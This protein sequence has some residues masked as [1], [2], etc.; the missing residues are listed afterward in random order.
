MAGTKIT[1][2]YTPIPKSYAP[3][4]CS[5]ET[6]PCFYLYLLIKAYV[7]GAL[8]RYITTN[9]SMDLELSHAKG[10]FNLNELKKYNRIGI[11]AAGSG[12]TPMLEIIDYL[13]ERRTNKMYVKIQN[14]FLYQF[15]GVFF[16]LISFIF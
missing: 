13:L 6:D 7:D 4:S 12:L 11:L 16:L 14:D 9:L 5:N 10:S 3:I 15:F 1:R 8:T 2:S